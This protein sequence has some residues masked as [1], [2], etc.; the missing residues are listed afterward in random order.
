MH[1]ILSVAV[2]YQIRYLPDNHLR[3]SIKPLKD[4]E[5]R[6]TDVRWVTF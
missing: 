6:D 5:S 1:K 2:C 4:S 3:M